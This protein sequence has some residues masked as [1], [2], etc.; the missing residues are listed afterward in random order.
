[1]GV[2]PIPFGYRSRYGDSIA[3]LMAR[4]GEIAAQGAAAQGEIWGRALS[5]IGQIGAGAYMAH[6]Q[7]KQQKARQAALTDFMSN[8]PE[9]PEEIVASA[10][11][12]MGPDGLSFAESIL[13]FKSAAMKA[14]QGEVPTAAE[15]E[16]SAQGVARMFREN[17]QFVIDNWP[18]ISRALRLG[19]EAYLGVPL[20][21]EWRRE[22]ADAIESFLPTPEGPKEGSPAWMMTLSP[23]DKAS[24]LQ[25]VRQKGEAERTPAKGLDQIEA[26]A[27]ARARGTESVAG[28]RRDATAAAA[29][30]KG[31]TS[32][33]KE[34]QKQTKAAVEGIQAIDRFSLKPWEKIQRSEKLTPEDQ[35]AMIYAF[36]KALDPTSVVREGEFRNTRQVGLGIHE[37]AFLLLKKWRTGEQLTQDQVKGMMEVI[38]GTKRT[39][40]DQIKDQSRYFTDLAVGYDFDP[41]KVVGGTA[42]YMGNSASEVDENALLKRYGY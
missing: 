3:S 35:F 24:Y 13:N 8:L 12:I 40:Q 41:E 27:A 14:S 23:E 9:N 22:Y 5:N 28:P 17:P 30:R 18:T 7:A 20:S 16:K 38:Q 33:R 4:Q 29:A 31:E 37:K 10:T 39:L 2:S 21:P 42:G 32:L 25:N 34:Y 26:E 6:Q 36:N 11:Q 15:F 1:M 19:A